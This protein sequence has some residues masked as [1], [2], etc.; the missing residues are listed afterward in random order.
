MKLCLQLA[1]ASPG[2][3]FDLV[4][5][6]GLLQLLQPHLGASFCSLL[7]LL[8]PMVEALQLP[9]QP[10]MP[11]PPQLLQAPCSTTGVSWQ[12]MLRAAL[13]SQHCSWHIFA[14][15]PDISDMWQEPRN[16]VSWWLPN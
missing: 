9:L 6:A 12:A 5:F 11:V 10:L 1:S 4:V 8:L 14:D 2:M 16:A 13:L 15:S 3:H 7:Q